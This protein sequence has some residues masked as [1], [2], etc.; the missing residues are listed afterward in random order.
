M[1]LSNQVKFFAVTLQVIALI[2]GLCLYVQG[3]GNSHAT[4]SVATVARG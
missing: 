4:S 3:L 1:Q 2:L